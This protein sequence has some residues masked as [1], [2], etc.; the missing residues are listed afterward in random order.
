MLLRVLKENLNS[1]NT[2]YLF[3]S[4]L[5]IAFNLLIKTKPIQLRY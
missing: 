4:M 5:M 3:P 2:D 1:K